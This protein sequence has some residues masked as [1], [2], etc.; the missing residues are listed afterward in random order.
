MNSQVIWQGVLGEI[1]VSI[2][3]SSFSTWFKSTEL[4]IISDNEVAVLSPNPFVLTQLEK[5]YYQRIADGLKRNGLA[6]STIHFRPKKVATRR[7]RLNRDEPHS[8]ATSPSIIKQANKSTTNLNPRYTFDNFIVGSSN[9]LAHAACQAIAANPGTKYNP[10]YLY[11]GSGLGKTHLMQAVGNEIIKRQP[12]AR[13][14]YTTTETFVSEF[15]DSIRFKKKGFS[16]K[17]RNVD[18]LIV[19][20]MQFIANKEKTQDEFFHTFNDLHQHDKQIIISSDKPPKSIP[21]LTD[22]LRSR[23]EWGMTI[24]VQMPDYETRCAIVTA[25]AGLSNVELSADVIEYLATNFKTNIRELEG[26]LNQLLAYAEM[27]NI[28]PD[29]ETAEGL[30]GNIKRSRPQHITAKQIIDKTARHFGVEVKD[31]CSPRRD[32][33]IMQPRQIAMYLLR[34]ELKMSFP[35]IAQELGRKDHT[36]AIHS[37]DKISKEML[38]SVNIREQINDIRDKLYV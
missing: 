34:S 36:T 9:D 21:T 11:G 1:E 37:V 8:T 30:L 7:Q 10:L 2:P 31:V 24:D 35:K 3:P 15:L 12:S 20:D 25:K 18:V 29:A 5:R 32:K 22:R 16:D 14:L 28:T 4:D 27:Q 17:Y 6:V 23:F 13:V 26:A 19:D 33:Y 38:I